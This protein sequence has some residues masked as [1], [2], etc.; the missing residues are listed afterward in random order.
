MFTLYRLVLNVFSAEGTL[1]H[2]HLTGQN[3]LD[4]LM[5]LFFKGINLRECKPIHTQ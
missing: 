1:F 4:M 3:N 2:G 5:P